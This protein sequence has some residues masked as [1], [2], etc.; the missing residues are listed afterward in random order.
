MTRLQDWA[1]S[2]GSEPDTSTAA[3][4]LREPT[5]VKPSRTA[6][7]LSAQP[8]W[9]TFSAQERLSHDEMLCNAVAATLAGRRKIFE[10]L[11]MRQDATREAKGNLK[12]ARL[13]GP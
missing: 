12:H 1:D 2:F 5:G 8:Q 7:S 4:S 10:V 3:E 11:D 9:Q 6:N 13:T